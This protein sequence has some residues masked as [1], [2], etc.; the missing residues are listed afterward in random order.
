MNG[1]VEDEIDVGRA[2]ALVNSGKSIFVWIGGWTTTPLADLL[3]I[4]GD[5]VIEANPFDLMENYPE[6]LK[7]YERPIF[8]CHHGV[9]SYDLISELKE[10]GVKGY[11]LAGGIEEIKRHN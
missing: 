3:E 6:E 11:S 1:H 10:I 4:D 2:L 5:K 9:S 7:G 8:V